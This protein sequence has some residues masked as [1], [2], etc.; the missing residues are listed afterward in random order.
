M[1][2]DYSLRGNKQWRRAL[3][4]SQLRPTVYQGEQTNPMKTLPFCT[5]ALFLLL[6]L[7]PVNNRSFLQP[8]PALAQSTIPDRLSNVTQVAVGE[9]HGQL[10][11]SGSLAGR[12]LDSQGE[13]VAQIRVLL[14]RRASNSADWPLFAYMTTAEDGAYVFRALPAGSYRLGFVDA[15]WPEQYTPVFYK[16]APALSTA[17]DIILSEGAQRTDIDM[18]LYRNSRMTGVV[19]NQQEQPLTNITI[20]L[21]SDPD[22]DG[23]WT[24]TADSSQ[25][26]HTGAYTMSNLLPGSYRVEF[27]D[28]LSPSRYQP[29]FYNDALTLRAA[30]TITLSEG[31]TLSE[32]NAQLGPSA[33]IHG[34]VTNDAGQ[35]VSNTYVTLFVAD[36]TEC[37][38]GLRTITTDASG[39][40]TF[41]GVIAGSYHVGFSLWGENGN[42]YYYQNATQQ[43]DATPIMVT[44]GATITGIH[45][46]LPTLGVLSGSV[47]GPVGQSL[48]QVKVTAL[49][50]IISTYGGAT[51]QVAAYAA[52]D[53]DGRYTIN[54]LLTGRYRLRFTDQRPEPHLYSSQYYTDALSLNDAA[55]ITLTSNITVSDLDVQLAGVGQISG[56]VRDIDD[57]PLSNI[58][59]TAW[60][61]PYEFDRGNVNATTDANGNYTLVGVDIGRYYLH[62]ADTKWPARYFANDY[63]DD[64]VVTADTHVTGVDVYL[65]PD[66]SA[67]TPVRLWLP[68]IYK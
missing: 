50:E 1:I 16:Q 46:Q 23:R 45:A 6:W 66:L 58:R 13:P 11:D 33:R 24:P 38:E 20:R 64:V 54:N 29:A 57:A 39:F 8:T 53:A 65:S 5:L 26:D 43:A 14:Y 62:F 7:T 55:L 44:A 3:F 31:I 68:L 27:T 67:V 2:S 37:R 59:V 4:D 49:R 22:Q 32:I 28:R 40:Y 41:T 9:R 52:T 35:P 61:R 51:W 21:Y 34:Q 48:S 19:T 47:T 60:P 25:S 15:R 17:T 36:C 42:T 12:V 10:A 30:T 63:H 56:Q 18:Q